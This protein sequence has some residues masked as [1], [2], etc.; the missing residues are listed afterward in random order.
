VADQRL[1]RGD[2]DAVFA[3]AAQIVET[4]VLTPKT[5]HCAIENHVAIALP[6][7]D[8]RIRVLSPCQGVHAVQAVVARALGCAAHDIHVIK[9]AI[10]G[11]FGGKAEAILEPIV[12]EL[13]RRLHRPVCIAF[14]RARTFSSTR[15]R[16]G[17]QTRIRSAFDRT[18]RILAR[19]TETLIDIGAYVTGG[20][21]LPR[22]FWFR[23][24]CCAM[25][26]RRRCP[27]WT[28]L[29]NTGKTASGCRCHNWQSCWAGRA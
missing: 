6:E 3:G 28:A 21:Y 1:E 24:H 25:S 4:T 17:S 8:G 5:H 18:G 19:E 15:M 10:G 12:A 23:R 22:P 2:R 16:S 13:A 11:S 27:L 29:W 9:T 7:P 20:H 26:N 14:D